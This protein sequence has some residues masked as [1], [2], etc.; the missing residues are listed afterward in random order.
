M[1]TEKLQAMKQLFEKNTIL[2]MSDLCQSFEETAM[3]TI[4]RYLNE[5][6]YYSSYNHR[7][8]YYTITGIPKFNDY[9]LWGYK[10]ALFSSYGNLKET[11]CAQIDISEAGMT[12]S[13]LT[14][15]LSVETKSILS[16][17]STVGA[18]SRNKSQGVYTYFSTDPIRGEQQ[19]MRR[20]ELNEKLNIY[21]KIAPYDIV[22]VL[23]AYIKGIRTPDKVAANLRNK[24]RSISR[25]AVAVIFERFEL[26][27]DSDGKKNTI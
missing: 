14:V 6:G 12:N 10:E 11:I 3:R 15:L 21:T 9:G 20:A 26:E 17:L 18:I 25:S 1:K 23:A 4:I 16:T 7:G 5:I 22:D 8:M 24:G 13:E 27:I 19:R 2:L